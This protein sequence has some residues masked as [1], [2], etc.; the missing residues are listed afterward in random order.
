MENQ[1]KNI[2]FFVDACSEKDA[3]KIRRHLS[4][5]ADDCYVY[6]NNRYSLSNGMGLYIFECETDVVIPY[7]VVENICKFF[8]CRLVF[9]NVTFKYDSEL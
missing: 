9:S 8:S 4:I 1:K 6:V 3:E 2:N 5:Y 7:E